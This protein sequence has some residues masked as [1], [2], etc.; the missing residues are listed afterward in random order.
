MIVT[1]DNSYEDGDSQSLRDLFGPQHVDS[2]IRAAIGA[3]WLALPRERKTLDE[4]EKE[5]RRLL[6]RALKNMREDAANFGFGD[7]PPSA[8]AQS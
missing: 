8:P 7:V 6:D 1:S 3:C 4:V 5:V 2:Q